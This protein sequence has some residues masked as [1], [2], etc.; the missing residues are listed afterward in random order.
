M[1]K[2]LISMSAAVALAITGLIGTAA[3]APANALGY[4]NC[5]TYDDYSNFPKVKS[6]VYCD[7]ATSLYVQKNLKIRTYY[8]TFGKFWA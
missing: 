7:F 2:R 5:R 6:T 3:L 1:R 8:W 4:Q